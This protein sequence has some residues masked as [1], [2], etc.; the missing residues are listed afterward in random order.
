[1]SNEYISVQEFSELVGVPH[2]TIYRKLNNDEYKKYVKVVDGKKRINK[3]AADLFKTK[4]RKECEQSAHDV[5]IECAQV[6][7]DLRNQL[8]AKDAEFSLRKE[9]F[10]QQ[11]ADKDEQIAY[12]KLQL[13]KRDEELAAQR[14]LTENAQKLH[15]VA[16]SKIAAIEDKAAEQ[17][18]G[19]FARW[20]GKE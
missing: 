4:V 8:K 3:G 9:F 2:Q 20:F 10:E 15:L 5:R 11:L 14:V 19:L 12:L 6:E 16:E 7:A 18:Q 1:M 13:E 17:K